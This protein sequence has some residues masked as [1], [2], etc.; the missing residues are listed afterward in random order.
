MTTIEERLA[1]KNTDEISTIQ[2][3]LEKEKNKIE[4]DNDTIND[5]ISRLDRE[6][7]K[8]RERKKELEDVL[9]KGNQLVREKRTEIKIAEKAY[10]RVHRGMA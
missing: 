4:L 1:G 10:W 9:R 7:L 6:V 8:L 5:E 2:V 3:E